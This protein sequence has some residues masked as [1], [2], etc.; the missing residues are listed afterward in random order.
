MKTK[1]KIL[2]WIGGFIILYIGVCIGFYSIQESFYFHLKKL[3]KDHVFQSE[4]DFKEL[5]INTTDGYKLNG[6]L[7]KSDSSRGLILFLHGSGGNINKYFIHN[8]DSIYTDLGYDIFLLD[9]RGY[10]KSEGK[11][12]NEKQFTDDLDCVYSLMKNMYEEEDI[13]MIGFSLGTFAASYLASKNNPKLLVMESAFFSGEELN[14]KRFFFLPVSLLSK[15]K[16]ETYKYVKDTKAP[17]AFFF[18]S[19]DYL[20]F[21]KRW[22]NL[23]KPGDKVT[24]LEGEPHVDFAHNKQYIDELQTLLR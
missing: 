7:V 16:L 23:L 9:Y 11:I 15:Y 8:R 10:G 20:S 19:L 1:N 12:N 13:V 24:I 18:G 14:K 5:T 4:K 17:I 21:D 3:P 2:V 22:H 6:V